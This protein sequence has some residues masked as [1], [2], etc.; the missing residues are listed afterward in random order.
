MR[1]GIIIE[2][3]TEAGKYYLGVRNCLKCDNL[4]FGSKGA[5]G[6]RWKNICQ[7]CKNVDD[8]YLDQ[9][10]RAIARNENNSE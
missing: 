5:S 7:R 8:Q 9:Q 10:L 6:L 1:K 3:L 2:G 4:T